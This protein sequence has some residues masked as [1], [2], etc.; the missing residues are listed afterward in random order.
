[1]A[2][3]G[4][5]GVPATGL[6]AGPTPPPPPPPPGFTP[7]PP[8]AGIST[9]TDKCQHFYSGYL[10]YPSNFKFASCIAGVFFHPGEHVTITV[11]GVK[12]T[13]VHATAGATGQFKANMPF[14]WKFCGARGAQAKPPTFTAQGDKG[15]HAV[16]TEAVSPCPVVSLVPK[17]TLKESQTGTTKLVGFGFAPGEHVTVRATASSG[18]PAV[19]QVKVTANSQGRISTTMR[20]YVTPACSGAKGVES[21]H[22]QGNHGTIITGSIFP[23]RAMEVC[24]TGG[25]TATPTAT[26]SQTSQSTTPL[27]QINQDA[28]GVSLSS[29]QFRAGQTVKAVVQTQTMGT[30]TAQLV[31]RYANGKQSTVSSAINTAGHAVLKWKV[32]AG[33]SAGTAHLSFQIKPYSLKLSTTVQV[34]A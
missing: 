29:N 28:L 10:H 6:A 24:P 5:S 25:P 32:P 2:L 14:Q 31:V 3:A 23:E 22:V 34:A 7:T 19:P 20:I 17:G 18:Y 33:T 13:T 26:S 1:M 4:A 12:A 8:Q 16:T 30:A 27:A 21:L 15:S 11:K 9:S